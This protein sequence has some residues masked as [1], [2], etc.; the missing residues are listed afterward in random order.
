MNRVLSLA[1]ALSFSGLLSLAACT[2]GVAQDDGTTSDDQAVV[3]GK[4][5]G[6]IAG[7]RCKAG[8]TCQLSGSFPDASGT[9]VTPK[10]GELDGF[11]GGIAGLPCHA[12]LTCK[13]PSSGPPPGA[14]GMPAPAPTHTGPPPGAMGMPM[15]DASGT[16]QRSSGPPPGAVGLPKPQK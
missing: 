2:A 15:A 7:L 9:C 11:C 8:L 14:M 3:K 1:A 6:G 16:C 12:G 10:P 13:F 5:C 4:M